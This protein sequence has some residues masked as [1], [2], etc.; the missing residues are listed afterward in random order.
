MIIRNYIPNATYQ[1]L[2]NFYY[3]KAD[4]SWDLSFCA[5]KSFDFYFTTAVPNKIIRDVASRSAACALN[6]RLNFIPAY[7]ALVA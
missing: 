1:Q 6:A 5:R 7:L 3:M 2:A 4:N